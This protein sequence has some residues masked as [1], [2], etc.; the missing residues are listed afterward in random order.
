MIKHSTIGF[1]W[2]SAQELQT[3]SNQHLR[4][5]QNGGWELV[6]VV[7]LPGWCILYLKKEVRDPLDDFGKG[8]GFP[9]EIKEDNNSAAT[10]SEA[11]KRLTREEGVKK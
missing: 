3:L 8:S 7:T 4:D 2:G 10:L 6:T 9:K 1:P 11:M 5:W